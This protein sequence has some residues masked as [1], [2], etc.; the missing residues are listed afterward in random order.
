MLAPVDTGPVLDP[1]SCIEDVEFMI[2]LREFAAAAGCWGVCNCNN[3]VINDE[4]DEVDDANKEVDD[5]EDEDDDEDVEKEEEEDDDEDDEF[6]WLYVS[7][8]VRNWSLCVDDIR[9][10]YDDKK[11]SQGDNIEDHIKKIFWSV[12]GIYFFH[13]DWISATSFC[14]IDESLR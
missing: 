1:G 12:S 14:V 7:I 13:K 5:E 6:I 2:F 9:W 11:S 3:E 8:S 10:R 4:E